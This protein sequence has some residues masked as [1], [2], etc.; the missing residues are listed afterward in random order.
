MKRSAG[1]LVLVAVLTVAAYAWPD[2]EGKTAEVPVVVDLGPE[3]VRRIVVE[4]GDERAELVSDG[5]G[6]WLPQRGTPALDATIMFDAEDRLFPLRAYR[7]LSIRASDAQFG[8]TKPE[9]VFSVRAT[10]GDTHRIVFGAGSFNGAGFYARPQGGRTVYLVPRRV[11]DDLRSLVQ[12]QRVDTP[13]IVDTEL[14]KVEERLARE[15]R[16]PDVS[17][18]LQQVLETQTP[19][20]PE[21]EDL[22]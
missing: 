9:I 5:E 20:S 16:T 4:S 2:H 18:W 22:K 15:A 12:G 10:G 3:Q 11:M 13:H 8:L 7:K 19:Q 1:L 6:T 17:P 14:K 21:T